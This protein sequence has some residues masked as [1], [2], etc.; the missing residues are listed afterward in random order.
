MDSLGQ[1]AVAAII[2]LALL[3]LAAAVV[4]LLAFPI[5]PLL[6]LAFAF[7]VVVAA[8]AV[9]AAAV[10]GLASIP[11]ITVSTPVPRRAGGRP[12]LA[13]TD[14]QSA[15]ETPRCCLQFSKTFSGFFEKF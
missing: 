13:A 15:T 9:S 14:S 2:P 1:A 10:L 3:L 4:A 11:P 12:L 5:P 8:A 7:A 6:L